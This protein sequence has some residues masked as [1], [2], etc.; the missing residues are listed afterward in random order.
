MNLFSV[1]SLWVTRCR[2]EAHTKIVELEQEYQNT[3][4]RLAD[5]KR[6]EDLV[7]LSKAKVLSRFISCHLPNKQH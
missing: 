1:C 6:H 2:A 5:V 4:E 7:L 3:V